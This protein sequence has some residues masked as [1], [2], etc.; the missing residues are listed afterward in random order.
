MYGENML[1]HLILCFGLGV[2][3]TAGQ[4]TTGLPL[5]GGSTTE[6]LPL[7]VH[8]DIEL[9]VFKTN[10]V[11][12]RCNYNALPNVRYETSWYKLNADGS[13]GSKFL[14]NVDG[15]EAHIEHR[16]EELGLQGRVSFQTDGRSLNITDVLVQD[17][18][19]Y[20]CEVTVDRSTDVVDKASSDVNLKVVDFQI[21]GYTEN[22]VVGKG[23]SVTLT[24]IVSGSNLPSQNTWRLNG[25]EPVN[26]SAI[27]ATLTGQDGRWTVISTFTFQDDANNPV[28]V[29][30]QSY[31]PL[32]VNGTA[33]DNSTRT[34]VVQQTIVFED[35]D[36]R[37][38]KFAASEAGCTIAAT[39]LVLIA[40]S[41]HVCDGGNDNCC[42]IA[43]YW[44]VYPLIVALF[45]GVVVGIPVNFF[46][47]Q[48]VTMDAGI[49]A[50]IVLSAVTPFFLLGLTVC[51]ASDARK[52]HYS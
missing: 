10:S 25:K 36:S 52:R 42:A 35:C 1:F 11:E 22:M 28:T 17:E 3:Q 6:G 16:Q 43:G 48:K 15:H 27:E 32:A 9:E 7:V 46:A 29:T 19:I 47:V 50:V 14:V 49:A 12:L 33:I 21:R 51:I 20:R 31:I 30:F 34:V 40:F 38:V 24:A 45:L 26:N 23:T 2:L 8:T 41:I 13:T 44:I 39:V 4:R 37:V 5:S 18:G